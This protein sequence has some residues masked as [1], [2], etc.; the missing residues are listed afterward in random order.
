[1][2][3]RRGMLQAC[4]LVLL[5]TAGTFAADEWYRPYGAPCVERENVFEFAEKPVVKLVAKDRYEIMFAVKGKCDATVA[6]VDAEGRAVRHLASGVLGSNAPAP[7]QKNSLEQ[8]IIWDGKDDLGGY[9]KEPEK[10]KVRV[11]LGLKPVFH[12][13][14]GTTDP[15]NLPISILGFGA[16]K[17]G[18]YVFTLGFTSFGHG[19][20]RKFDHDGNYLRS[21]VPPPS[22]LPESKLGGRTYIEYEP[23]RK[24]HH[25]PRVKEDLGF[26]GHAVSGLGHGV[27]DHHPSLQAAVVNGRI[28]FC[29]TRFFPGHIFYANLF[30]LGSDGS[31]DVK[32]LA[33][34]KL[35]SY[36][37]D[38]DRYLAASPDGKWMYLSG[39]NPM[40]A[41]PLHA[42]FRF[43]V[44]GDDEIQPFV[45][46]R[47]G[48][49]R[50]AP[51][52][53]GS[54][55]DALNTPLGID[56]DA[57]GRLYIADQLNNRIQ[58]FSAEGT[59]VKTI[60]VSRPRIVQVHR[61]TGA[62]YVLHSG[63]LKGR[64]VGR[65]TK[66][67][68]LDQ[69]KE[70]CHVDFIHA[71]TFILDS[72]APTPRLWVNGEIKDY[73]HVYSPP[74][75]DGVTILDERDGKLQK[76]LAFDEEVRKD[77]GESFSGR[78]SGAVFDH[79]NCD[80]V[81]E[82]LCF[83][84]HKRHG[85]K[86]FDL[87]TG[88]KLHTAWLPLAD[89]IA[90]DKRGHL[91][92]H[93]NTGDHQPVSGIVRMDPS[94]TEPVKDPY[95]NSRKGT[96]Q[97]KEVP[98]DYGVELEYKSRR[99]YVGGIAVKDQ[100]GAKFFQDG[101]GVNMQGDIAEVCNIFY[102][103]Q[104]END[105]TDV[106]LEGR[107][108]K[109]A[110]GMERAVAYDGRNPY[111]EFRAEI[112]KLQKIGED[113]YYI[114]R[115]PGIP[116]AGGTVWIY[117]RSGELRQECA[118]IAGTRW[119]IGL[120]LDEDGF[121]Y[122]GN[123]GAKLSGGRPFL[124]GRGGTY[125]ASEPIDRANVTP[126]TNTVFKGRPRGVRWFTKKSV[127]PMEPP[128]DRPTNIVRFDAF[129]NPMFGGAAESWVEGA[130]WMYAGLSPAVK[131]GCSCPSSRI[132]LDWYKRTYVPEAYRYSIGILDTNGNLI[133]HVGRYGNLDDALKMEKGS[134]DIAVNRPRFVGGTD[135]YMAFDDWGESLKVLRLEY[136]AEETAGISVEK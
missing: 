97:Y 89:D 32:G 59:Y 44:D 17:E 63:N 121:L 49:S 12:G 99:S 37:C 39:V 71:V 42:V 98:Y 77:A 114:P 95:G 93:L 131:Q 62:I 11:M 113:V 128:P 124:H 125:G 119:V 4:G 112:Q 135:N 14:F 57:A 94:Q 23:G 1:M 103:P 87:K 33:G 40:Y 34:R 26:A 83:Q 48:G 126:G 22:G 52:A 100:K 72:W 41:K 43:L 24:A 28:Y 120:H 111:A 55:N 101:F 13:L 106:S 7:F 25:G 27:F 56:V 47:E 58:V 19:Q 105:G 122:F 29:T 8:K 90:F 21:I 45:G 78:W 20:L 92:V 66:L 109:V 70:K 54:G 132:H 123:D 5:V 30:Y 115:R 73:R 88:R 31:T 127:V 16:D 117:D 36:N 86:V 53:P 79:V 64:S 75:P 50:R 116:L 104:M 61:K 10:L 74:W 38:K 76:F 3:S 133:M 102:V 136:H 96:V 2:K 84:A 130:E 51:F 108:A 85:V 6:L 110:T 134:T 82:Q 35:T 69:P 9:V 60:P 118:V 68:S 67:T 65:I 18:V 15:R 80:P 46:K 81:R 107:K 91:H 129:G